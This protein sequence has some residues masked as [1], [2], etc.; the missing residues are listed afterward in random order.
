MTLL[1][2]ITDLQSKGLTDKEVFDQ[3]QEFKKSQA[4][5]EVV[6]ENTEEEV[7]EETVEEVEEIEEV[8]SVEEGNSND[9]PPTGADVD[10]TVV[11]P[12]ETEVTESISEDGSLA[13]EKTKADVVIPVRE[14]IEIIENA[15]ELD[16]RS[17][18]LNETMKV[19]MREYERAGMDMSS[20]IMQQKSGNQ[21]VTVNK[22]DFLSL[23]RDN[24]P[25]FEEALYMVKEGAA[26]KVNTEGIRQTAEEGY[27]GIK[28]LKKPLNPGGSTA[29]D[30]PYVTLSSTEANALGIKDVRGRVP[31]PKNKSQQFLL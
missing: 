2:F 15:S 6:E 3:A 24:N 9:S 25:D 5:E 21:M 10:Q 19:S 16:Y 1:E 12:E 11:A 29:T 26:A 31:N 30:Q 18:F 8:E 7:V 28:G 13:S 27:F 4:T 20:K 23:N 14:E 22:G 17:L